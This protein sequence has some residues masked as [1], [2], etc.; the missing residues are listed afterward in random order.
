MGLFGI[1]EVIATLAQPDEDVS[2]Q[3]VK[4]RELWPTIEE[5]RKSFWP[6]IRGS[7]IGF[8]TGLV[9]GHHQ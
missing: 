1:S 8:F 3:S 2:L 9:P 7:F 5:W 4:F 6:M